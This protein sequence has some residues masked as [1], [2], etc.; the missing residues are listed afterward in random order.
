MPTGGGGGSAQDGG[1]KTNKK[2]EKGA[3]EASTTSPSVRAGDP[4][5]D[6]AFIPAGFLGE[7]FRVKRPAFLVG[8]ERNKLSKLRQPLQ[9]LRGRERT[10]GGAVTADALI[11]YVTARAATS[12]GLRGLEDVLR[13]AGRDHDHP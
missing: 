11:G 7:P 6:A 1:K 12:G 3:G 2:E 13:A 5:V 10:R 9:L 4:I 8:R